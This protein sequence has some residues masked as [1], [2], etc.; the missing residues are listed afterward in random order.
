MNDLKVT[1]QSDLFGPGQNLIGEVTWSSVDERDQ[2]LSIRLIWFTE[3]KGDR[4][5]ATVDS[6]DIPLQIDSQGTKFEFVLPSRPLSFSG[7]I[8]CLKW[9]VEAVVK[10]SK[11]SALAEFSLTDGTDPIVLT[12]K[13]NDLEQMGVKSPF[14]SLGSSK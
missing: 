6:I 10:P 14:F 13:S 11:K 5:Y 1:L 4:D 7:K 9:A 12:D 8:I 3:G 2:S